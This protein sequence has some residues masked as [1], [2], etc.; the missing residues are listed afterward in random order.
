MSGP[1]PLYVPRI[2]AIILCLLFCLAPLSAEQKWVVE[3]MLV[4]KTSDAFKK[5]KLG[6][7]GAKLNLF[8]ASKNV[9]LLVGPAKLKTPPIPRVGRNEKPK[10]LPV[11]IVSARQLK[12]A[13]P[14]LKEQNKWTVH[15]EPQILKVSG[16][17]AALVELTDLDD[18]TY[19]SIYV[20]VGKGKAPYAL[21]LNYPSPR[22][23]SKVKLMK[24]ILA[25]VR[26]K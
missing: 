21:I 13:M 2:S 23:P 22:D 17:E 14:V 5:V 12:K 3:N 20:F 9:Q 10:P 19:Q 4:L 6:A 15:G 18:T 24:S 26:E 16:R 1:E 25:T 7:S 11:T 8:D